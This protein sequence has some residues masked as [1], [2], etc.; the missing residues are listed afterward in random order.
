MRGSQAASGRCASIDAVSLLTMPQLTGNPLDWFL[1]QCAVRWLVRCG[2]S[3]LQ[4]QEAQLHRLETVETCWDPFFKFPKRFPSSVPCFW[5]QVASVPSSV[6]V[7]ASNLRHPWELLADYS[8]TSFAVTKKKN[9]CIRLAL[10]W[11]T[12]RQFQCILEYISNI[13]YFFLGNFQICWEPSIYT[14]RRMFTSLDLVLC[15][16]RASQL[17]SRCSRA[18]TFSITS[19]QVRR[20][21]PKLFFAT[22]CSDSWK[23]L[24][25][26]MDFWVPTLRVV[27][28]WAYLSSKERSHAPNRCCQLHCPWP[29]SHWN[30]TC[31]SL[32]GRVQAVCWVEQRRQLPV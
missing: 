7:L 15:K 5:S 29:A 32:H 6:T 10:I 25:M 4:R 18:D 31:I 16:M 1:L 19:G 20:M 2:I 12:S 14:D 27:V 13:V 23:G 24:N 21:L 8:K 22:F 17:F 11:Q 28:P 30:C 9:V 3:L 26:L